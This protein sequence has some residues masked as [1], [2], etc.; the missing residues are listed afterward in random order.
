MK[1]RPFL[2]ESTRK[3]LTEAKTASGKEPG[4]PVGRFHLR[5]GATS[6]FDIH[7]PPQRG[8]TLKRNAQKSFGVL[9]N[10]L[11]ESSVPEVHRHTFMNGLPVSH[12]VAAGFTDSS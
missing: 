8:S 10:W 2:Y 12:S 3:Y 1:A 5:N 9:V 7:V 4:D 11:Y 6:L